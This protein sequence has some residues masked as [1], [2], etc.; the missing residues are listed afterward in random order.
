MKECKPVTLKLG[1]KYYRDK[2]SKE[3]S[4]MMNI[5]YIEYDEYRLYWIWWI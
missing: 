3:Y 5:D 1:K 2:W 4:N